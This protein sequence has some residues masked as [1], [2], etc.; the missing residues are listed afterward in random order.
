MPIIGLLFG[1]LVCITAMLLGGEARLFFNLQG[2]AVVIGGTVAATLITTSP[3][4]V[5]NVGKALGVAFRRKEPNLTST[6]ADT[7]QAGTVY[8][9]RGA[10][11]LLD[12]RS[13]SRFLKQCCAML[14]E[15][16][17][18][19][20]F[21]TTFRNEIE[22]LEA[23]HA[24]IQ[25]I[26]RRMGALA[27]SFGMI[28]TVVGLVHM[29]SSLSSPADLGPAM[30]LALLTTL[31]GALIG[32]M[33]MIPLAAKL[34]QMTAA[35]ITEMGIIYQGLTAAMEGTPAFH[36]EEQLKTFLPVEK[37]PV[38]LASSIPNVPNQ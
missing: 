32:F 9:Q 25:G 26:F 12:F 20:V 5:I 27:P 31:Y 8:Q 17:P 10:V 18:S 30:S 3:R 36:T 23:R 1:T 28:G 15:G 2:L 24:R 21:H 6:I 13:N 4:D 38:S 19:Q 16:W 29:L 37:R 34:K 35:E 22:H 14:S 33:L 11:A 7:L